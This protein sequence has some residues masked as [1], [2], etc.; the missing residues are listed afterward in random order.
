MGDQNGPSLTDKDK[1]QILLAEYSGLRTEITHRVG[2]SFQVVAVGGGFLAL[3]VSQPISPRFWAAFVIG[4][5]V[6]GWCTAVIFRDI[7]KCARRVRQIEKDVNRR[8]GEELLEWETY[9]GGGSAGY[10]SGTDPKEKGKPPTQ[11]PDAA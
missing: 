6:L 1:I 10:F 5:I 7:L 4:L 8:A 3:I 9:W 2:N 11:Q